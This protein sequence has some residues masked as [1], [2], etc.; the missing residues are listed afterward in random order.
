MS[1]TV[2]RCSVCGRFCSYEY[3]DRFCIACGAEQLEA[4]CTCG[5]TYE[6][7][8]PETGDLHCPRCG[9]KLRGRS[10]EFDA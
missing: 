2:K 5:R 8:V 6:F 7:A 4:K 1:E 9:R 10:E 3:D